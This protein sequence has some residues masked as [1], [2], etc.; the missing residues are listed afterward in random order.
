[1]ELTTIRRTVGRSNNSQILEKFYNKPTPADNYE[2][3][4]ALSL[5][6]LQGN[7]CKIHSNHST[8][9]LRNSEIDIKVFYK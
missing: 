2:T 7:Y 6:C 9:Q 3:A 5:Y 1:M 4:T 8:L